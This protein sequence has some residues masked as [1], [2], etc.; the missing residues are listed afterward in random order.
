MRNV[1][2][3]VLTS[4]LR[5]TNAV[6]LRQEVIRVVRDFK[7]CAG[8]CWCACSSCCS[9]DLAVEAPVGQV[10]GYVRQA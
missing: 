4:M 2:K 1:M 9:L 7:C 5:R 10:I 6:C 8:C 3:N